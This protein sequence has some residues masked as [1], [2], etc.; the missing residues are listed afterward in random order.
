[1]TPEFNWQDGLEQLFAATLNQEPLEDA[2]Q[3]MVEV[4]SHDSEYHDE[5]LFLFDKGKELARNGDD[6][7]IKYIN[8]SGYKVSSFNE[9]LDLIFAFEAE[10][11]KAFAALS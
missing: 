1:M 8:K 2:S 7:I 6:A 4:S 5:C 10:Y 9:A 11:M 3:I